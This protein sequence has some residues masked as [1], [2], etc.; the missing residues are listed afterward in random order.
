MCTSRLHLVVAPATEGVVMVEDIGGG[1]H[2]VSLLALDPP[3]P[4]PGEWLVV[5]S[6]YAIARAGAAEAEAVASELR[7]A[8]RAGATEAEAVA[9][10]LRAAAR[11]GAT[12]AEAVASELGAAARAD[13]ATG[14]D[15][16]DGDGPRTDGPDHDGPGLG[17]GAR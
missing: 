12:E 6:G 1:R 10:E 5:H 3:E 2:L 9:S 4:G 7:A 13:A 8:A 15:R 11:A 17:Q 14:G 16:P